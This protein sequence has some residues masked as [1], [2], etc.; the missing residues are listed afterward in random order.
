MVSLFRHGGASPRRF[1]PALR[2][3]VAPTGIAWTWQRAKGP[4]VCGITS[5]GLLLSIMRVECDG[6][7]NLAAQF[8]Q[9]VTALA[10]SSAVPADF[11]RFAEHVV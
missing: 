10:H 8:E 11:Q 7:R 1:V 4:S 9:K 5:L 6:F 3:T 2:G